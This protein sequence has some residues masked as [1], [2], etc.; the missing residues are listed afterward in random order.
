MP[1]AVWSL[2][3]GQA[4]RGWDVSVLTTD[5]MAPHER[6]PRGASTV[7]GVRIVRMR[8]AVGLV[9]S[10]VQVSTPI[11]WS[12]AARELLAQRPQLVH[13]HELRT[14]EALLI[15]SLLPRDAIVVASTHGLES[16]TTPRTLGVRGQERVLRR[17]WARIN[18]VIV[19]SAGEL[20][21]VRQLAATHQLPWSETNLSIA[22]N[23]MSSEG[24]VLQ[25]Y[26]R[27]LWHSHH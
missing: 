19:E 6:L 9:T 12:R 2:A 15:T 4:V 11:G 24:S 25:V 5:A 17:A 14:L 22:T 26:E 20:E 3:R 23:D 13:L 18:H 16:T 10:W 21:R 1:G 27:L 7:E 8:N